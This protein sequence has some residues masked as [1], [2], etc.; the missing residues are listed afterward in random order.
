MGA[1]MKKVLVTGGAGF[2]GHH[3][4]EHI[5]KNTDWEIIV[6]DKLSYASSGFARLRDINVLD[7]KRLTVFTTDITRPIEVGLRKEI[8]EVDYI[9][10]TAAETHVDNSIV[11]ARPFAETNVLG[12]LEILELA[13]TMDN[14]QQMIYFSTDE[15]FGP[16]DEGVFHKEWD[17]Y[18]STNPYA[19]TKASGE[20]LCMA[21]ANTHGIPILVSHTMN[22]FG[23][24]QHPEKF[25]PKIMSLV[26]RGKPVTIHADASKTKAGT[27]H[28]IH[29]RNVADAVLHLLNLPQFKRDKINIVGERE[30]SN[31][32]MAQYV[33][34]FMGMPLEYEMVDF[35]SQRPGHDLRYALDGSK[36][37]KLGWRHPKSFEES[38]RKVIEWTLENRNWLDPSTY[39]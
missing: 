24:R 20:E 1:K 11:Y 12:T 8:G 38:L 39:S 19:A 3:L 22:L 5:L 13:R 23:E 4:I 17:A 35:H 9:V 7:E 32:E 18:N 14:L 28:Y 10:H 21:F 29:C 34:G 6:L 36:L 30:V 26:L 2:F 27:R 16:A 25:I 15:V 33:A 37:S 31:L